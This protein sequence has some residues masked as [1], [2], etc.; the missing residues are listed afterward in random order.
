MGQQ[1]STAIVGVNPQ[2]IA[3]VTAPNGSSVKLVAATPAVPATQG[4]MIR[5]LAA[6]TSTVRIG[7]VNVSATRGLELSAGDSV[8]YPCRDP[9]KIYVWGLAASQVL[10]V[11]WV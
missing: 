10:S 4:V 9:S 1:I 11:S 6:N 3:D 8:C 5:A 7:D 2:T